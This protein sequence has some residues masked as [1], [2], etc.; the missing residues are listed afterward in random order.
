MSGS[1]VGERR[2]GDGREPFQDIHWFNAPLLPFS[3]CVSIHRYQ[4]SLVQSLERISPSL[5]LGW[6]W[7]RYIVPGVGVWIWAICMP[8]VKIFTGGGKS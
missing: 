2:T 1:Q 6:E 4:A 8:L 3:T 7:G 5:L